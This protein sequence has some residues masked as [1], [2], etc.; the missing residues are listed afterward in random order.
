MPS[1]SCNSRAMQVSIVSPCSCLPPGN[2]SPQ[3]AFLQPLVDQ[4]LSRLVGHYAHRSPGRAG[5]GSI[6]HGPAAGISG[7]V[8]SAVGFQGQQGESAACKAWPQIHQGLVDVPSRSGSTRA[9]L[10]GQKRASSR[11][12]G[13]G[14]AVKRASTRL[15]LPSRIGSR[16]LKALERM[17]PAV[18]RPM[19]GNAIHCSKLRGQGPP[20]SSCATSCSRRAR[21][22]QPRPCR[23]PP[24][25]KPRPKPQGRKRRI[26]VGRER[27]GQLGLRSITSAIQMP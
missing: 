23:W 22:G 4:H 16:R 14:W 3:Q 5:L 13:R 2:S 15:T 11:A 7:S 1:S 20:T 12:G 25:P 18:V 26:N 21:S 8:S 19:P 27:N 10:Q 24:R 9:S 17:L 6:G